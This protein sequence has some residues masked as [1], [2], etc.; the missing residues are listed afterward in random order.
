MTSSTY[1]PAEPSR[2]PERRDDIA[3]REFPVIEKLLG[4]TAPAPLW[5]E[6]AATC[7]QLNEKIESGSEAE[8]MRARLA[9]TAFG[10]AVDIVKSLAALRDSNSAAPSHDNRRGGRE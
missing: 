4:S 10:R 6:I 8:R 2:A 5:S 7:R 1:T 3:W 9:L